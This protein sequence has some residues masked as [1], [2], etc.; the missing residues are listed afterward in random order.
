MRNATLLILSLFIFSS[1]FAQSKSSTEPIDVHGFNKVYDLEKL[2]EPI[3]LESEILL[4]QGVTSDEKNLY[5][6]NGKEVP[7]IKAFRLSDGKYM[8][9]F[10][11]EGQGPGEYDPFFASSFNARNNQI[12]TQDFKYV[13]IHQ[14]EESN[15][16]LEFK[17]IKEVRLPAEIDILNRGIL[18]TDNIY[19]GSIMFTEKDFVTF[20]L[21]KQGE[22]EL[23]DFGDYPSLYPEIPFTA[24]HHLYQGNSSYAYDGKTLLRYYSRAP[25][26]RL[27]DLPSG[28]YLDVNLKPKN[29]QIKNLKTDPRDK[30]IANGIE[31]ISYLSNGKLGQN[32]FVV[33][34]QESNFKRVAMTDRGNLERVPLTDSTILVFSREGQLLAKLTPPDWLGLYHVTPDD[35][36]IVFHP[37]IADKLFTVDLKQFK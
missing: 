18:I 26:I 32:R 19:G 29:E 21:T 35:R 11:R 13:R 3:T 33:L 10:G 34:Y 9:G 36:L 8:G 27:F 23:K 31:M 4:V 14:V 15:G 24:Y 1:V 2:F 5:V 28:E 20:D 17:K 37:E 25:I 16:T 7:I 6:F 30:S 22:Q 12:I